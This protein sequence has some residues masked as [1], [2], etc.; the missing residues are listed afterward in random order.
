VRLTALHHVTAVCSDARR[1]VAFYR[2]LGF[3]LVKRTINYDDPQTYHLY[4][5]DD[6]G[7]PGTLLTFFEWR[8]TGR[9][10][11]GRGLVEIVGLTLPGR[12]EV[13]RLEDPDGLR[14][15]IHPGDRL[16]VSHV[17]AHGSFG[18]Y[19][20]LIEDDSP[21]RFL[22]PAPQEGMYGTG[23][24]HHIAWRIEDDPGLD[25]WRREL[26]DRGLRPTKVFDRTYCRSV[27]VRMPDGLLMELATGGP[28]VTADE[29]AE[30]LG[31][32]LALPGWL[33]RERASLER[34]L[35]PV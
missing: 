11:V 13:E 10:R 28:G 24:P 8:R 15:E 27:Y 9:G 12:K 16:R 18:A 20:G 31:T 22:P 17:Y 5:G 2:D 6:E 23:L 34:T 35:S 33:E 30:S 29:P 32:K 1:T 25:A 21:L 3:R 26:A 7:A 4:L 14:L 19:V